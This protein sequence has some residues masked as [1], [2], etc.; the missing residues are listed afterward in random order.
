MHIHFGNRLRE[1]RHL[2]GLTQQELATQVGVSAV[3]TSKSERGLKL[4]SL[5][6]LLKMAKVLRISPAWL[7]CDSI[8]CTKTPA[9]FLQLI[10]EMPRQKRL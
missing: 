2:N 5:D 7:L 1:F 6:R 3:F 10:S 9:E 4:R 8:A